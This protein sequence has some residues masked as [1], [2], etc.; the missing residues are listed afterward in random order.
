M[1]Q[2]LTAWNRLKESVLSTAQVREIDR[3]AVAEYGMHSLVLMENAAMGCVHW[4]LQKFPEPQPT[5]ILCGRGNNGGDGLAIARHLLN[6]GWPCRVFVYG[7]TDKLTADALANLKIITIG[8]GAC[9]KVVEPADATALD[10]SGSNVVIDAMLGT[11]AKGNPRPPFDDWIRAAN[12]TSGYR[13]A[14]DVP[15][16]V[17]AESG[18]R[19]VPHFHA[20]ATLTFVARKPAMRLP[21]ASSMFGEISVLPIGVPPQLIE[22]VLQDLNSSQG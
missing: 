18:E 14:I 9:V 16:G 12:A 19:G 20:Q 1:H 8:N 22:R 2:L 3:L 13:V 21:G 6:C 5:A 7:P 11:G 4:L 10:L 17:D 15:T